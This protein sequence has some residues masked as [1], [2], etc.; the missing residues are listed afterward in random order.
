MDDDLAIVCFY[1]LAG[2]KE[3]Y[4]LQGKGLIVRSYSLPQKVNSVFYSF[5]RWSIAEFLKFAY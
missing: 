4:K 5:M 1:V 2:P 3:T